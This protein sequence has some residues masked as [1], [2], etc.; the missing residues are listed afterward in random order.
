MKRGLEGSAFRQRVSR[1]KVKPGG[2]VNTKAVQAGYTQDHSFLT[3][4]DNQHVR[5]AFVRKNYRDVAWTHAKC[6]PL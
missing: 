1:L 4:A 2:T 5:S 3:W 6:V